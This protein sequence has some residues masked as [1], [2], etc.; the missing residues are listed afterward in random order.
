MSNDAE[1]DRAKV[2]MNEDADQVAILAEANT[3]AA[4][5][6]R[7]DE[8]AAIASTLAGAADSLFYRAEAEDD[9]MLHLIAEVINEQA[10]ALRAIK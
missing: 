9:D 2:T 7:L 5:I 1:I 10:A 3:D 4:R 6:I 8:L